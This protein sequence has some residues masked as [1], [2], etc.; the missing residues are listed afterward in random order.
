M[1]NQQ[2]A[3][4]LLQGEGALVQVA[5]DGQAAVA[6]I[7]R[8]HPP[9]DVVLMD[10]Q[11]PVMDGFEATSIIRDDMGLR[12]LPIVAMTANALHSDRHACLAAG[13]NEHVGKPFDL[14]K[15]V[16][17]LRRQAQWPALTAPSES[18]PLPLPETVR[19]AAAAAQIDIE[20]ALH[21]LG[22]NQP[23]YEKLLA[24]FVHDLRPMP[25]ELKGYLDHGQTERSSRL[26]HTL[27]GLAAT[28]GALP[29]A[30]EAAAAEKMGEDDAGSADVTRATE[31]VCAAIDAALPGLEAVLSALQQSDHPAAQPTSATFAASPDNQALQAALQRLLKHLKNSDMAALHAMDEV[32]QGYEGA[33]GEP[34]KPL[35][36]AI[37]HLDFASAVPLCEALL[38]RPLDTP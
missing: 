5:N 35:Q 13:M 18:A 1:N 20:A 36:S 22:G 31:R 23:L 12:D 4:E 19:H 9:F 29:L 10:L 24:T 8:A 15:L 32:Q 33:P 37:D 2:V 30:Q 21:R 38:S 34:L 7:V 26:I 16:D 14:T 3:R 27:K 17:V 25:G 28:M 6:A 11:M